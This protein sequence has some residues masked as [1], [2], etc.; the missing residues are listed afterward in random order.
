[1]RTRYNKINVFLNNDE[2]EILKR[3]SSKLNISQSA[4]IRNLI[5]GYD[6]SK[7]IFKK[8]EVKPKEKLLEINQVIKI[9]DDNIKFLNKIKNRFHYFGYNYDEQEVSKKIEKLKIL[10]ETIYK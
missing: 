1:M 10:Q 3:D 5:I 6:M 2:T 8:E 7:F 4:Y 9:I